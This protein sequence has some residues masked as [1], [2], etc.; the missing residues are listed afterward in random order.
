MATRRYVQGWHCS[1]CETIVPAED[2][3]CECDRKAAAA[4][5]QVDREIRDFKTRLATANYVVNANK[6]TKRE[7]VIHTPECHKVRDAIA[8]HNLERLG[9]NSTDII[10]RGG[11]PSALRGWQ[12]VRDW[13]GDL[14]RRCK[15]CGPVQG[16]QREGDAQTL[17]LPSGASTRL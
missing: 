12:P 5:Q 10:A 15:Q 9:R 1:R 17:A 16:Q 7:H 3:P 8:F 2:W 11:P 4:A 6:T 14:P 13:P